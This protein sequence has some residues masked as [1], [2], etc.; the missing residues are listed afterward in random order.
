MIF[1]RPTLSWRECL[2][3]N[4]LAF[5]STKSVAINHFINNNR[6]LRDD[7]ASES[8]ILSPLLKGNT[9]VVGRTLLSENVF[10][11]VLQVFI[12]IIYRLAHHYC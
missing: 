11:F 6:V 7:S 5:F 9:M 1:I 3:G 2:K 10:S 4:N 12:H 8:S